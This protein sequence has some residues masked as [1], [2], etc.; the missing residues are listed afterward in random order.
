MNL[1]GLEIFD[2]ISSFV[3]FIKVSYFLVQVSGPLM[4]YDPL[5]VDDR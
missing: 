5:K 1:S 3:N 4:D 2:M